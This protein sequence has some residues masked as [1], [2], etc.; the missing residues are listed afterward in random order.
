MDVQD[1]MTRKVYHCPFS[2]KKYCFWLKHFKKSNIIYG[3]SPWTRRSYNSH[4]QVSK[5][6]KGI[7]KALK[8]FTLF[9]L[10]CFNVLLGHNNRGGIRNFKLWVQFLFVYQ[11]S[12]IPVSAK[13]LP[14]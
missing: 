4:I 13:P 11:H 6:S 10:F 1:S 9:V 14:Q 12:I 5:F 2:R 8:E 3:C 7:W